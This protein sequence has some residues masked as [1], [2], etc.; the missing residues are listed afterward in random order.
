MIFF[1]TFD[2]DTHAE[3][4]RLAKYIDDIQRFVSLQLF[5]KQ[6]WR[7]K[8][9]YTWWTATKIQD[10][11]GVSFQLSFDPRHKAL[12]EQLG[13]KPETPCRKF[14]CENIKFK[15]RRSILTQPLNGFI[16]SCSVKW[17]TSKKCQNYISKTGF[18]AVSY[19]VNKIRNFSIRAP[20][21]FLVT[22]L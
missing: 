7:R 3:L 19:V 2:Y 6:L 21:L 16:H 11:H 14:L 22:T 9:T 13:A 4:C 20:K 18:I 8:Q 1:V 15:Q 10:K 5:I 12:Q 17:D